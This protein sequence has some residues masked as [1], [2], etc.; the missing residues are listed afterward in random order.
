MKDFCHKCDQI[1]GKL[2]IWSHLLK[3]SIMKN[4]FLYS[5]FLFANHQKR[6]KTS[7]ECLTKKPS[8]TIPVQFSID[9]AL[10]MPKKGLEKN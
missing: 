4:V 3:K 9:R 10:K 6:R 2:R 5:A 8:S 1:R 7:I